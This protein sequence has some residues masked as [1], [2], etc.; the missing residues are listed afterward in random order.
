MADLVGGVWPAMFT[1][2]T[3]ESEPNPAMIDKLLEALLAEGADGIYLLGATGQGLAQRLD[4]RKQVTERVCQ[5]LTGCAA[6]IVHVGCLATE[7]AVELAQHAAHCGA[8]GIS[9]VPPVYFPSNA[10]VEME[11]YRRIAAATDLPFLPYVNTMATGEPPLPETEYVKRL[12]NLPNIAGVKL[13][14]RNL[15]TLGLIQQYGGSRLKLYS[16]ADEVVCLA[17]LCDV[18]GAIGTGYNWWG[19]AVR[20]VWNAVLD[21][22]V[23]PARRFMGVFQTTIDSI[24]SSGSFYRFA[25]VAM[26]LRHGVDI[27]PGRAPYCAVGQCWSDEQVNQMLTTV[28]EAA[29]V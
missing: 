9:A 8:N 25:R 11:H 23:A 7:D 27:G 26:K 28:D 17:A 20:R 21:G 5:Q 29:G 19:K 10:D 2:M 12:L 4:Q 15:Y 24:L 22:D 6:V 3:D 16:G 14:T 18:H 1:P 13:T